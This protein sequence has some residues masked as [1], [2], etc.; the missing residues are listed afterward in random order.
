MSTPIGKLPTQQ[1]K[2][3]IDSHHDTAFGSTDS[4]GMRRIV[5]CSTDAEY[6]T[7][8]R[9]ELQCLSGAVLSTPQQAIEQGLG[10]HI[11]QAL[12]AVGITEQR[13]SQ[14]L[15][16][17]CNCSQ[18]IEKLNQLGNW[19]SKVL[20]GAVNT[21]FPADRPKVSAETVAG[22]IHDG[23]SQE[24]LQF[25][26]DIPGVKLGVKPP[27]SSHR[28]ILDTTGNSEKLKA[29]IIEWNKGTSRPTYDEPYVLGRWSCSVT[30][31]PQRA[32]TS[33]SETLEALQ[34]AGFDKLDLYV[35]SIQQLNLQL[36]GNVNNVTYRRNIRTYSH[37]YLTLA[38]MY[39]RDP[40]CQW[41]AIFQDDFIAVRNLK[42]YI[43]QSTAQLPVRHYLN[44]FTFMENETVT[45]TARG[46]LPAYCDKNGRQLG[47]GAVGLVLPHR[48]VTELLSSRHMI[49]RRQD[50]VRG[51][52]SLDG[53]VVEAM[54][55]AGF[56]EYIHS[57]SLLQHTGEQ[58]SMGNPWNTPNR[59]PFAKTFPGKDTDA[60]TLL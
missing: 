20:T 2:E 13:V 37:W 35:D 7:H 16:A 47:R 19:A 10:D 26:S 17:P 30:T 33:L 51:H 56:K 24:F 46:W 23:T 48:A 36:P 27:E 8:L 21:L 44:L 31:V 4:S 53:A 54:N 50:S 38:E 11:K 32:S 9:N 22:C 5:T 39:M 34:A 25:V 14:W 29:R 60:M 28:R 41:Y 15:G 42:Q 52:R 6:I 57:P 58:S 45:S 59:Y 40:Y 18:R 1:A 49:D 55:S 12:T 3:F 43:E